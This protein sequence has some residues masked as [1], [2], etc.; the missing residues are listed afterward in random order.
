MSISLTSVAR[1]VLCG[2]VKWEFVL[3]LKGFFGTRIRA[4]L[5]AALAVGG[6]GYSGHRE[7]LPRGLITEPGVLLEKSQGDVALVPHG[8][9]TIPGSLRRFQRVLWGEL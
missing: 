4:A 1:G 7:F 3:C 6:V 5:Q 8:H 9:V 2:F